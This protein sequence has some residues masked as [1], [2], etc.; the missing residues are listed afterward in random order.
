[1]PGAKP[2]LACLRLAGLVWRAW[3]GLASLWLGSFDHFL[4]VT[5]KRNL[6]CSN[7]QCVALDG[8]SRLHVRRL[9]LPVELHEIKSLHR[10]VVFLVMQ[11]TFLSNIIP[12]ERLRGRKRCRDIVICT[13]CDKRQRPALLGFVGELLNHI[14]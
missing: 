8:I 3:L 6:S 7:N 14:K 13:L 1:M 11:K 10:S 2:S 9:Y 12:S 5:A 4:P